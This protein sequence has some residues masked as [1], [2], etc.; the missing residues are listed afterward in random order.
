MPRRLLPIAANTFRE[1]SQ[2]KILSAILALAPLPPAIHPR[3]PPLPPPHP[4]LSAPSP[5][6]P[7]AKDPVLIRERLAP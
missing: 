3:L 2:N 4:L 1:T 5:E 7:Q 6:R